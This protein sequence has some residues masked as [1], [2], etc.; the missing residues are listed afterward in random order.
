MSYHL[1]DDFSMLAIL[2]AK[3]LTIL[4]AMYAKCLNGENGGAGKFQ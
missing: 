2:M 4:N 3:N 1:I